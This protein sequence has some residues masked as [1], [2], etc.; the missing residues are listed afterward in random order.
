MSFLVQT[1]VVEGGAEA[2]ERELQW[3]GLL[4]DEGPG[5]GGPFAPYLQSQRRPVYQEWAERLLQTGHAYR[6][7]CSQ[8]RLDLIRKHASRN[9]EVPRYDNR[10]RHLTEK[11]VKEKLACREA[12]TIRLKLTE[13]P[14]SF[15]DLVTGRVSI[16][17]SQIE[18]DPVLLKSDG[19]PTYHLAN[20][21]DDH[22]MGISHVLRGIEWQQSTPKHLMIFQAFGLTPPAYGHLP[23]ILNADGSKLSKRSQDIRLDSLRTQ[24]YFPET[25]VNYLARMGE[26]VGI[27]KDDETIYS[28]QDLADRFSPDL[29]TS[30]SNR[31][32]F[33]LLKNL[34]RKCLKQW[35][36][37][38]PS[39]LRQ[40]LR[41]LLNDKMCAV[42]VDDH[43]LDFVLN[44][45]QVGT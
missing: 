40:Q 21:V 45:S 5:V 19:F 11:E 35:L 43:R 10:C 25:I 17:L 41:Q 34:N 12:F 44:W 23:L 14:L 9:K 31:Y 7:F 38:D 1:R 37:S 13:G 6:C 29:L 30:R 36:R 2:I 39:R 32:D 28:L 42:D 22:L 15:D 4:P 18:A 24:G 16:D 26:A 20:V 33:N 3:T 27:S 8:K